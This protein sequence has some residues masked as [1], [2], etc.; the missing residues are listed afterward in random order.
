MFGQITALPGLEDILAFW[1]KE[2]TQL[3]NIL[4]MQK[5]PLQ[6]TVKMKEGK[7][8]EGNGNSQHL[9]QTVALSKPLLNEFKMEDGEKSEAG[10]GECATSACQHL[11][12]VHRSMELSIQL[13][14]SHYRNSNCCEEKSKQRSTTDLRLFV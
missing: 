12:I 13:H 7:A 3:S 9:Q 6:K 11:A 8:R 1:N 2:M 14:Y 5:M 10:I 4:L